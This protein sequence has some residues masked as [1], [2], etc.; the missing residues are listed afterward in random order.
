[1]EKGIIFCKS[2]RRRS[3]EHINI[4]KNIFQNKKIQVSKKL[5]KNSLNIIIENF[6]KKNFDHFENFAK[7]NKGKHVLF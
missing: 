2:F 7:N 5:K 6:S 3:M 4:F 1:M